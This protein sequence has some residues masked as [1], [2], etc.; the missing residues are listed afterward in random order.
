VRDAFVARLEELARTDPRIMLLT[1]DL[2][3]G[4][5]DTFS[6]VLPDQ[7]L[8][9][10]VAE[11]NLTAVATGLALE[12]SIVFTYSI[13]NFPTLRCLEQIRNDACYHDANVK[14]V[15]IGGG[16]SYGPLGPSHH[17]TE[18]LAI[19]RALPNMT[20]FSPT[21]AWEVACATEAMVNT[22]GVCYLRLDKSVS[23]FG[24]RPGEVFTP[25]RARVL[26]EGG[27]ITI[28]VTGG[29]AG[30]A[31]GAAKLLAA[32]GLQCRVLSMHTI[33]P[34][35]TAALD[36]AARETG[37]VVTLEE[38]SVT[39]GLGGAVS[40]HCLESGT[41]PRRFARFGLRAGFSSVVGSQ[42]YLRRAYGLDAES[43]AAGIETLL[44]SGNAAVA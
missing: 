8:N 34:L 19:L 21:D 4:V 40:E 10:G 41:V 39:G 36:A 17:A 27:D 7:F 42:A 16:F 26:R 3:F 5:L 20:I 9:V 23:G 13:G 18:D 29:I 1:G 14:L 6:K 22:P 12:G 33:T 44:R 35:D 15:C 38:H 37:G 25:G 30:E 11:Q 28:V 32:R 24:V 43:V 31:L 2:G